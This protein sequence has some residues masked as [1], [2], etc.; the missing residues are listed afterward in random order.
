[1]II[2]SIPLVVFAPLTL[3]AIEPPV[4]S[5]P[6]PPQAPPVAVP[7]DE[8]RPQAPQAGQ[9]E[10]AGPLDP[11]PM[12]A[13]ED[14]RPF[15]GVILD[16]VPDL[17]AGHLQLKPG[18]GVVIGDLVAGG[19]AEKAQL[20]VGDVLTEVNGVGVGS[21]EAVRAEVEKHEVGDEIE[22][23]VIQK[24]QQRKAS[25]TLGKAP[26]AMMGGAGQPN[27]QL[28]GFLENFPDRHADLIR[29]AL[30]RNLR[31]F[32]DLDLEGGAANKLQMNLM[33]RLEK[34][35]LNPGMQLKLG[36]DVA[37]ESSIR[38]LDEEGSIEMSSRDGHKE[39]RVYG[40]DGELLW[41]GPYDTPQDKA[42]V[43][44]GIRE[45]LE[46]LNFDMD[47]GGNG[48]KLRLG[49]NRFRPLDELNHD[50]AGDGEE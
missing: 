14:A 28:D 25:I 29:E 38:L 2:R 22:V 33:Q 17:L 27:A 30:E 42:A 13:A 43:P 39:A 41:E 34:E 9:E 11:V 4:D 18:Q 49:P 5:E 35:M 3:M 40:Q 50:D 31:A 21:P 12:P 24:G 45:R 7:V 46:K 37:A 36:G 47:F 23:S 1:M 44:D 6:I 26:E 20:A 32:E 19:P 16:P 15:L 10:Q 8:D 48:L